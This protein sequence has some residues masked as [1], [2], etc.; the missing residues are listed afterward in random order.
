MGNQDTGETVTRMSFSRNTGD[1]ASAYGADPVYAYG[2][3][4]TDYTAWNPG[5]ANRANDIVT[6]DA[7]TGSPTRPRSGT[8]AVRPA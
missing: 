6:F 2:L 5:E 7:K 1:V 4:K 3:V 8:T